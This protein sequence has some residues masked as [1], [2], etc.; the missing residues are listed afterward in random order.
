VADTTM[1]TLMA[2]VGATLPPHPSLGPLDEV[3]ARAAAPDASARLDAAG[4]AARLGALA[5]ALPSPEPLPLL[6]PKHEAPAPISGFRAPGV[7]ELTQVVAAAGPPAIGAP[8]GTKSGPGEVFDAELAGSRTSHGAP[9]L[10]TPPSAGPRRRRPKMLWA[11][12]VVALAVLLAGGTLAALES[13]VFTPSHPVPTLVNLTMAQAR[14][15]AAKDHFVLVVEPA[16]QSTTVGNG[17]IVSQSPP[18]GTVLK[19]GSTLKVVPSIGP[20]P[21]TIPSL[22]GMTC[23]QAQAT[24]TPLHLT[25]VCAAAQYNSTVTLNML[26]NW[27]FGSTNDPTSAPYG[28]SIALVPSAGHAPVAVPPIPTTYTYAQAQAALTAV[29]LTA[30]EVSTSSTTVPT[31]DVISVAPVSGATAPF[32]SAVTVTVSTGPPTTVVPNMFKD[33]V[34]QATAALQAAGLTVGGAYGPSAGSAKATVIYSSPP[35]GTTVNQGSAV[36]LYTN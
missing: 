29:G 4:F 15:A 35:Q 13:H 18:V 2:R 19:Q 32:G 31:G 3:L 28:S 5:S 34:A 33:T 16:V 17:S 1:G 36:S 30:T 22:T 6:P 23:A 25:G 26:I 14:S 20:P 24:L 9:P 8:V 10:P 12:V 7:E 21:V 27:S 11:V